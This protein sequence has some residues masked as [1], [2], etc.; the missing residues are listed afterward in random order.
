M[1]IDVAV[2]PDKAWALVGDPVGVPCWY[3]LYETCTLDGD[4]RT[5]AR[6]DGVK[7]LE[8][9]LDRDDERRYYAYGVIEGLPLAHHEASFEVHEADGGSRI[10]W[11]TVA[12][13]EDPDI[14][15]EARL[16]ERQ[17][18]ALGGL[19]RVLEES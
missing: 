14:D 11:H 4:V 16:A 13:H 7:L 6:A 8:R 18:E 12:E 3:P 5:L 17:I 15:M 2:P 1:E 19:K 9:L 10:V